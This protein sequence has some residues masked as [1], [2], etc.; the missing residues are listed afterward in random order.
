MQFIIQVSDP[1]QEATSTL[2]QEENTMTSAVPF[3]ENM[4]IT[5]V[6]SKSLADLGGKLVIEI[7]VNI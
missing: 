4:H 6:R 1:A 3:L 7:K 5:P 2:H